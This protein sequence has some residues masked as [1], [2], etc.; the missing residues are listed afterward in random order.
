MASQPPAYNKVGAS[1]ISVAPT[2]RIPLINFGA[3]WPSSAPLRPPGRPPEHEPIIFVGVFG[4]LA[5][6]ASAISVTIF[7]AFVPQGAHH[8]EIFTSAVSKP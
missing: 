4:L 2:S 8:R 7:S 1:G 6:D 5:P 3:T